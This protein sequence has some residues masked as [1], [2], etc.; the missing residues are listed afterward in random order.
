MGGDPRHG[1]GIVRAV[2][3]GVDRAAGAIHRHWPP[4]KDRLDG[5]NAGLPQA[6]ILE[7]GGVQVA[8]APAGHISPQRLGQFL[9]RPLQRPQQ[10]LVPRLHLGRGHVVEPGGGLVRQEIYQRD[11]RRAPGP[12][13]EMLPQFVAE[14]EVYQVQAEGFEESGPGAIP[15]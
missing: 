9:H 3:G 10:D 7:G 8:P 6:L 14:G 5:A 11:R 12:A 1:V 4:V 13:Q 2:G 15:T